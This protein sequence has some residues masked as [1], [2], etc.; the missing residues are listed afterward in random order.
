V[1][2]PTFS[3]VYPIKNRAALFSHTLASL[4]CSIVDNENIELIVVDQSSDDNLRDLLSEYGHRFKILYLNVDISKYTAYPLPSRPYVDPAYFINVGIKK[5]AG[6][7][8]ILSSPEV[9][10][11]YDILGEISGLMDNETSFLAA[12]YNAYLDDNGKQVRDSYLFGD[13]AAL[14]PLPGYYFFGAYPRKHMMKIGGIEEAYMSG[15]AVEDD[16]FG[17]SF[18]SFGYQFIV[19]PGGVCHHLIHPVNEWHFTEEH[20]KNMELL[21]QRR[22]MPF[23]HPRPNNVHVNWGSDECIVQCERL[24]ISR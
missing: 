7:Y 6:K 5:S 24:D 18:L 21:A 10:P 17:D 4:S 11:Q 8:V 15:L 23:S 16:D 19:L 12:T 14:L 9:C 22:A 1:S 3:I 2:S 13:G 20:K